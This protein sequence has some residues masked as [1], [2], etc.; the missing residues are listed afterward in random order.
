MARR[1][2]ARAAD[3]N[4]K[5]AV[6]LSRVRDRLAQPDASHPSFRELADSAG[7]SQTT[8]RHYLGT[9]EE[10]IVAVFEM[11]A[12]EGEP[13]LERMK[14]PIKPFARSVSEATE[15][16]AAGQRFPVVRAI[17]AIGRSEGVRRSAAGAAYRRH[18]LDASLAAITA[19]FEAHI[20]NGEMRPCNSTYA[21]IEF[22]APILFAFEHQT[23][24]RGAESA[25]IELKQF[26]REHADRFVDSFKALPRRRPN[27]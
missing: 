24:L 11:H 27:Q 6:L 12:R 22:S 15:F 2:G 25:P 14:V 17:H 16:L 21:A 7:V 18:I 9:L 8:L 10:L 3:Y 23:E 20:R 1:T 4:S 5:Y 13:Y 26:L 19:R